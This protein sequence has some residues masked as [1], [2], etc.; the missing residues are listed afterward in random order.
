MEN[1]LHGSK[2]CEGNI[3]NV[4]SV[5]FSYRRSNLKPYI[6]KLRFYLDIHSFR[7]VRLAR[8]EASSGAAEYIDCRRVVSSI[9][10]L[11]FKRDDLALVELNFAHIKQVYSTTSLGIVSPRFLLKEND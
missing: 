11:K 7:T 6:L 2:S 4:T 8:C 5:S 10:A 3:M 1:N 9:H